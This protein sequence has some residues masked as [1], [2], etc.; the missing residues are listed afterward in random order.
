MP[1]LS[2]K[3]ELNFIFETIAVILII[4]AIGIIAVKIKTPKN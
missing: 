2:Q 1:D 4:T 3:I